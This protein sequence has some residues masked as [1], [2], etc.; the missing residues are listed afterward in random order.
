MPVPHL[1]K[2]RLI[3]WRQNSPHQGTYLHS[4]RAWF[5]AE[6]RHG[7]SLTVC[8]AMQCKWEL[9]VGNMNNCMENER[10]HDAVMRKLPIEH[11]CPF[12]TQQIE[13]LSSNQHSW[14]LLFLWWWW[15]WKPEY[16]LGSCSPKTTIEQNYRRFSMELLLW[17]RNQVA[18]A[19]TNWRLRWM[20]SYP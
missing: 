4:T 13:M 12:L 18:Y 17:I 19:Y 20:E 7:Y 1:L 16:S 15:R 8:L 14:I 2:V 3:T 9:C 10:F 6:C 11:V 5:T